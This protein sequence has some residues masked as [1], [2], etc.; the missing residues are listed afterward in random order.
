MVVFTALE[1]L[2]LEDRRITREVVDGGWDRALATIRNHEVRRRKVVVQLDEPRA[3]SSSIVDGHVRLALHGDVLHVELKARVV[4]VAIDVGLDILK[5][6]A[7]TLG[8][9]RDGR[10]TGSALAFAARA[11]PCSC[12]LNF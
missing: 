12:T 9:L 8:C 1:D 10:N 3:N 5:H 7:C 11:W 2:D 6:L 4:V